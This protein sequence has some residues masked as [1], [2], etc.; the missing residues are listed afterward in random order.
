MAERDEN[1]I[2][3]KRILSITRVMEEEKTPLKF[4]GITSV[5]LFCVRQ[6]SSLRFKNILLKF[7]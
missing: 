1:V 7:L 3:A 4:H 5:Q 6:I 2:N